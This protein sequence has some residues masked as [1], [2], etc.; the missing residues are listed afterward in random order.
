MTPLPEPKPIKEVG[1]P[2]AAAFR[3]IRDAGQPAVIRGLGA[4]WPAV[5]AARESD[6]ALL[7]YLRRFVHD[8]QV[9]A[10]VGEPEIEGRFFYTDD[11][12]QLNF[13]R[14]RS[15]LQPFLDRLLRDRDHPHP[16]AMAVQSEQIPQLL[17]GFELE[18]KVEL[19]DAVVPRAW[20]GNRIR[21]AP[22]YDLMENVGVVVAGRRRFTVFPPE[23]LVNLYPGPLELTPAGTPISLVDLDNP[24]LERFPRFAQAAATAQR[25]TL[26]PG[27]AIYIPYHWWHAVDS[28]EPVNF[29][30]NYWWNDAAKDAGSPYD[31]LM[32]AFFALKPLPDH[33]REVWRRVFDYYVFGTGLDPAEH[34]PVSAKGV[35][36]EATPEQLARMRATLKIIL[37]KL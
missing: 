10:I 29:F 13:T 23:Q 15:K 21:V 11:L 9:G 20:I 27:D 18:N 1:V 36:G 7:E 22:H 12:L 24:D 35:L 19:L 37:G 14:G 25:A 6:E 26:E 30:M 33:Q 34:L 5:T 31:A 2:D 4:G 17:P 3:A 16:I 32:Y 28:L 8:Q